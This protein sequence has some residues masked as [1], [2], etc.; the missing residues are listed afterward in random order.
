MFRGEVAGD[1]WRRLTRA[2]HFRWHGAQSLASASFAIDVAKLSSLRFQGRVAETSL[3]K[4]LPSAPDNAPD[5]VFLPGNLSD[6]MV[7]GGFE[8]LELACVLRECP[9][10][11]LRKL[12]Q[13]CPEL[14]ELRQLRKSCFV[15]RT[16]ARP[17]EALSSPQESEQQRQT[18]GPPRK[19]HT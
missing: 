13:L 18:E 19:K 12:F 1:P 6:P 8:V 5:A 9:V 3:S 16:R 4:L 2:A 15:S 11:C 7:H 14:A 10:P 17:P